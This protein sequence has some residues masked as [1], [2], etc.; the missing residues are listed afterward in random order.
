MYDVI[1]EVG[2]DDFGVLIAIF[3]GQE[4]DLQ[5]VATYTIILCFL[6]QPDTWNAF[7]VIVSDSLAISTDHVEYKSLPN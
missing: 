4:P 1:F 7:E 5:A 3:I 6:Y 2:L